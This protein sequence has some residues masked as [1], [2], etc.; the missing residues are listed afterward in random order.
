MTPVLISEHLDGISSI[1]IILSCCC[2]QIFS[3]LYHILA[4]FK[5]RSIFSRKSCLRDWPATRF[6]LASLEPCC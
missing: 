4:L 6:Q 1:I 3:L 5:H 2:S